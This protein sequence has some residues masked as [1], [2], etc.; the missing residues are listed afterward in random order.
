M[1]G[2]ALY[3]DRLAEL[4]AGSDPIVLRHRLE[5]AKILPPPP[6]SNE[7]RLY[8]HITAQAISRVEIDKPGCQRSFCMAITTDGRDRGRPSSWSGVIDQLCAGISDE[9]PRLFFISAGNT[10]PTQRHRYPDSNDTDNVQDPA[11][12]WNAITVGREHRPRDVRP[13]PVPRLRTTRPMR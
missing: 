11:Q 10:D 6:R 4:L 1:A 2:I 8:G 3:G 13:G 12:A 5:S 9:N 7:P